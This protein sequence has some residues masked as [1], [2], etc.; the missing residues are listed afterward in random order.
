MRT[1]TTVCPVTTVLHT[2]STSPTGTSSSTSNPPAGALV[3]HPNAAH[4]QQYAAPAAPQQQQQQRPAMRQQ[5]PDSILNNAA[6]AAAMSVLPAN[7]NFEIHK[8]VWRIQQAGA[9]QVALQ[10]PEG[11]LMYACAIADIL[12]EFAGGGLQS[13]VLVS[14]SECVERLSYC[15]LVLTLQFPEG[16]LMYACAIADIL[17]EFACGGIDINSSSSSSSS[18]LVALLSCQKFVLFEKI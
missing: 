9:R 11:L 5:V 4:L 10:L 1:S 14:V 15:R 12:Q 2:I 3:P 7:Y 13:R 16:L 17:Q 18:S 6:L 8:T